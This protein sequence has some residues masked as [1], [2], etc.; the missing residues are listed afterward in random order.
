[1]KRFKGKVKNSVIVLEGGVRLPDG[2]KVEV[3]L[4]PSR[5]KLM[6]ANKRK[7]LR[8]AV[9]HILANPI[10]RS[11]GIDEII[12]EM[13]QEVEQRYSFQENSGHDY[14]KWAGDR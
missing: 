6:E 2:T 7:R 9:Q 10:T 11:I 14:S 3:L 8:D 12:D 1:M 5:Q 13:K 4:P